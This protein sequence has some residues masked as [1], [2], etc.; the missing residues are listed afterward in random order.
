MGG[1]RWPAGRA[2]FAPSPSLSLSL[3]LSGVRLFV[4]RRRATFRCCR[5]F[6][7][8]PRE[9][10]NQ[11]PTK[12]TK[13]FTIVVAALCVSVAMSA[14]LRHA[15]PHMHPAATAAIAGANQIGTAIKLEDA[16][17]ASLK[18]KITGM[19]VHLKKVTKK[20]KRMK[21]D[22]QAEAV[23]TAKNMK[24]FIAGAKQEL[25]EQ[26]ADLEQELHEQHEDLQ[27][28]HHEIDDLV[29][30]TIPDESRHQLH[31]AFELLMHHFGESGQGGHDDHHITYASDEVFR[32][33]PMT[34][35]W[36]LPALNHG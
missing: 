4:A 33:P 16:D 25:H 7:L 5:D 17:V 30:H 10:T 8:H 35:T 21:E 28:M 20:L 6:L 2:S 22:G 34:H 11:Q 36:S 19:K 9:R 23:A 1:G 27:E 3:S 14:N 32:H 13:T 15:K 18:K 24:D 31:D 12:M 26:H 29:H